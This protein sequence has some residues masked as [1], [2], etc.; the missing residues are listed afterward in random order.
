MAEILSGYIRKL[1]NRSST[2]SDEKISISPHAKKL[3][4]AKIGDL[5]SEAAYE[6]SED[7]M[8]ALNKI[9]S[10]SEQLKS[11]LERLNKLDT[12]EN[13]V[14]SIEANLANLKARTAKLEQFELTAANDR[15]DLKQSCIF[16]GD[17]C[18]EI[19]DRMDENNTKINSLLESEKMLRDQMNELR[20]KNLYLKAYSRREDIKFFSIPEEDDENTEET[21]RNFME[22]DLGYRNART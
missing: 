3:K 17:S 19:Q 10:I 4:D 21:L 20:F 5:G 8:E 16:N 11:I 1:R 2:S 9:E 14:K 15:K 7:V 22:D 18:K 12:I 6:S 13:S